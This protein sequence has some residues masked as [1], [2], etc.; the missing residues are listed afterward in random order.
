MSYYHAKRTQLAK[1]YIETREAQDRIVREDERLKAGRAFITE[2][3]AKPRRSGFNWA[4][5][6]PLTPPAEAEQGESQT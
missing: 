4:P 2:Y 5:R 3:T 1:Q 6:W